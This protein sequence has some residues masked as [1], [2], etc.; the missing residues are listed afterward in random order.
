MFDHATGYS[1]VV[2]SKNLPF[3]YGEPVSY[4]ATYR[5]NANIDDVSVIV[6]NMPASKRTILR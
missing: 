6:L 2:G 4:G 5:M 3:S 1:P